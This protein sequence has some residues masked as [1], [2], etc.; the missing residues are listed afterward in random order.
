M[1]ILGVQERWRKVRAG[2]YQVVGEF[3]RRTESLSMGT[4]VHDSAWA[5]LLLVSLVMEGNWGTMVLE[6]QVEGFETGTGGLDGFRIIS[7]G[8]EFV[9][10]VDGGRI[11]VLADRMNRTC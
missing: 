9:I 2:K 10:S 4:Q 11:A 3:E 7:W 6:G 1:G 8:E 5:C